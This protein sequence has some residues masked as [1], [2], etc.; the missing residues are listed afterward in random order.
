MDLREEVIAGAVGGMAGGTVMTAFMT[1][2]KRI[3]FIPQ[4]LPLKV[5]RELEARAGW[6][7]RTSLS[8]PAWPKAKAAGWGSDSASTSMGGGG[9]VGG[10]LLFTDG[11]IP[12]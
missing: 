4:P 1:I 5:G 6:A 9:V 7:E 2:G 10:A 8:L 11:V 3:G 12:T